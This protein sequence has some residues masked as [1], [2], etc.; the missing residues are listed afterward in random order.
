MDP[1][2]AKRNLS[3]A[4]L[5]R[6]TTNVRNIM[7]IPMTCTIVSFC[8]SLLDYAKVAPRYGR[9]LEIQHFVAWH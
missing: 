3:A 6:M 5:Q 8:F 4:S 7:A 9:Y 1:D 2:V